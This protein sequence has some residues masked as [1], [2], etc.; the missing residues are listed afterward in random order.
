M[1]L[2][3]EHVAHGTSDAL[4]EFIAENAAMLG[5]QATLAAQYAAIGD[6]TG[7]EYAVRRLLAYTRQIVGTLADLKEAKAGG[8]HEG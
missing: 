6:D 4:R 2:P 3:F 7:L 1:N 8:V 5:I